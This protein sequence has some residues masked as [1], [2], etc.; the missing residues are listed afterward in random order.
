MSEQ[1]IKLETQGEHTAES[2]IQNKATK[3]FSFLQA[4]AIQQ[5]V[6][7]NPIANATNMR[8]GLELHSN[9][10]AKVSPGMQRLVHR[11]VARA[12]A[13]TLQAF[14]QAVTG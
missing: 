9:R 12:R 8:L 11:E 2:H 7:T 1:I 6:E 3:L 14:T 10:S 5:M 4:A 13:R